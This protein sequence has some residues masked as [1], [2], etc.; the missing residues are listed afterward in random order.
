MPRAYQCGLARWLGPLLPEVAMKRGK[1]ALWSG[2]AGGVPLR[3]FTG[4][5]LTGP[6]QP[7]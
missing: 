6:F 3:A 5:P 4:T 2:F 1:R 7:C